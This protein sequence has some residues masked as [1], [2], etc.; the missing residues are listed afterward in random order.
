MLLDLI[1]KMICKT[2]HCRRWHST[3]NHIFP[4]R[5][6][7]KNHTH[8]KRLWATVPKSVVSINSLQKW[9]DAVVCPHLGRNHGGL[10]CGTGPVP[11]PLH[12]SPMY[13]YVTICVTFTNSCIA[14]SQGMVSATYF[15][16]IPIRLL[17]CSIKI[18]T[19]RGV[20]TKASNNTI[21]S[22]RLLL[23]PGWYFLGARLWR[24]CNFI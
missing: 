2:L 20:A 6:C 24:D 11:V 10:G 12:C 5:M 23:Y 17:S 1:S 13:T 14:R 19:L 15:N 9:Q 3:I 18:V 21:A 7:I 4:P 22:Q 8:W 16:E